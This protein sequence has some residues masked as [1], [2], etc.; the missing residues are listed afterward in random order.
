MRLMDLNPKGGEELYAPHG[1]QPKEGGSSMRLMDLNP[2][3]E[4]RAL[5][6]S[7]LTSHLGR[8][9]GSLRLIPNLFPKEGGGLYAPHTFSSGYNLGIPPYM[10][11][12]VYNT[13]YASLLYSP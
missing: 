2:K 4:G 5:C 12:C 13:L 9:K 8:R 3:E 6:A 1:P 10:P 7:Y 11:P